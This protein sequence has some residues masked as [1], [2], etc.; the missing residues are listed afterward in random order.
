MLIILGL[1]DDIIAKY[2]HAGFW[3][4]VILAALMVASLVLLFRDKQTK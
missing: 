3:G 1:F 4:M 2:T